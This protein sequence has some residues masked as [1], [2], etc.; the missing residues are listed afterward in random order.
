MQFCY[1]IL[2]CNSVLTL[3]KNSTLLNTKLIIKIPLCKTCFQRGFGF[4]EKKTH[5]YRK[6]RNSQKI[7]GEKKKSYHNKKVSYKSLSSMELWY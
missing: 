1:V 4:F 2:L 7:K 5:L 6:V 3:Y